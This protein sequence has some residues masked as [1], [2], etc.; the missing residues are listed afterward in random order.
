MSITFNQIIKMSSND[1]QNRFVTRERTNK[2]LL[3][4]ARKNRNSATYNDVIVIAQ[5]QRI[6]ANKLVLGCFCPYFEEKLNNAEKDSYVIEMEVPVY[7]VDTLRLIMDYFYTGTISINDHNVS[8]IL[9]QAHFFKLNEVI[10]F[11]FDYL[12][13]GISCENCFTFRGQAKLYGNSSLECVATNFI[14]NNFQHVINTSSF[15]QLNKPDLLNCLLRSTEASIPASI[16]YEAAVSWTKYDVESRSKCFHE[17]LNL[18]DFEQLSLDFMQ[19]SVASEELVQN[20]ST[21]MKFVFKYL[22]SAYDKH[23]EEI[24]CALITIG[25]CDTPKTVLEIDIGHNKKSTELPD[26]PIPLSG[27]ITL[28]LDDRI[29]CVGGEMENNDDK[30][31]IVDKVWEMSLNEPDL[32]WNEV[33]SMNDERHVMGAA[34]FK[35]CL[36][37]AGGHNG[38]S[39]LSSTE[40]FIPQLNVWQYITP[41]NQ[42]RSRNALVECKNKLYVIGGGSGSDYLSSVECISDL[43]AEWKYVTSMNEPRCWLAAV[44]CDDT[45]YAIGGKSG[46]DNDKRLKSVEKYDP[47]TDEWSFVSNMTIERSAHSAAVMDDKIYVVGGIDT[48]SKVVRI[49]ECYDPSNDSWRVIGETPNDL[50]HNSLVVL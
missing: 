21:C 43:K 36:V 8:S 3:D 50:F 37:V 29:Y 28:L 46:D 10:Q 9:E 27:H 25:G 5:N 41:M 1:D 44:N 16:V 38:K 12:K 24:M 13:E 4:Y 14:N 26:L 19:R 18:I 22:K 48:E 49:I 7:D 42:A 34:I 15:K 17:L 39:R 11:C 40:V 33:A 30:I 20:D 35:N 2:N 31:K 6:V 23:K 47:E 32:K 45:I